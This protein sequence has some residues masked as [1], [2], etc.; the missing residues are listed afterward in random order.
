MAAADITA[1][2]PARRGRPPEGARPAER[3]VQGES[4]PLVWRPPAPCLRGR[5]VAAQLTDAYPLP[6]RAI[7]PAWV[8]GIFAD[9]NRPRYTSRGPRMLWRLC[10]SSRLKAAIAAGENIYATNWSLPL[11]WPVRLI[12]F[13]NTNPSAA[14]TGRERELHF[15][16][17]KTLRGWCRVALR[18][19]P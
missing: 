15:I 18:R 19:A 11:E 1:T 17:F 12:W 14:W 4:P 9:P 13:L 3:L 10:W 16:E 8:L 2:A 7:A 6:R 5:W